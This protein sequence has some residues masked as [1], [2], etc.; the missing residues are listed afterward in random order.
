M[1]WARFCSSS[2]ELTGLSSVDPSGCMIMDEANEGGALGSKIWELRGRLDSVVVEVLVLLPLVLVTVLADTLEAE[3]G[4]EVTGLKSL[5]V[6]TLEA[7]ETFGGKLGGM[8]VESAVKVESLLECDLV[9]ELVSPVSLP[10]RNDTG[11]MGL[12][13]GSNEFCSSIFLAS[14]AMLLGKPCPEKL[15]CCFSLS[16]VLELVL[17]CLACCICPRIC[18]CNNCCCCKLNRVACKTANSCTDLGLE[19]FAKFDVS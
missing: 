16:E 15:F 2:K 10:P 7:K 12:V 17:S 5:P 8:G 19:V 18:M 11:M 4:L 9:L 3:A 1:P 6:N 14:S 13:G